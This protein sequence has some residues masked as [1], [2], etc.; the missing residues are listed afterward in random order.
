M[1]WRCK[2]K[3]A[4][5]AFY[6]QPFIHSEFWL[7]FRPAA[8]IASCDVFQRPLFWDQPWRNGIHFNKDIALTLRFQLMVVF[9]GFKSFSGQTN[10]PAPYL[11]FFSKAIDNSQDDLFNRKCW[12]QESFEKSERHF[13]KRGTECRPFGLIDHQE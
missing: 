11:S 4:I 13:S 2:S 3:Q 7:E 8:Q 6:N 5:L 10:K 9:S 12:V 1:A